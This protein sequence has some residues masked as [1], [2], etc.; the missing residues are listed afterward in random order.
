MHRQ[1]GRSLPAVALTQHQQF[2]AVIRPNIC[3]MP[4]WTSIKIKFSWMPSQEHQKTPCGRVTIRLSNSMFLDRLISMCKSTCETPPHDPEL[5]E[6]RTSSSGLPRFLRSWKKPNHTWTTQSSAR[7]IIRRQPR[8]TQNKRERWV[9]WARNGW[10][11][12][13]GR[14]RSV[15]GCPSWRTEGVV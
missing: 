1:G 7:R 2:M 12:S 10:I 14:A 3:H 4:S 11:C 6:L 5:V 13:L 8:L 15:S 9:N